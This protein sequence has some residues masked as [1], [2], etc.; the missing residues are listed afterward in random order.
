MHT[1]LSS[2]A[3]KTKG[4]QAYPHRIPAYGRVLE[5]VKYPTG[6]ENTELTH[7]PSPDSFL[8][9]SPRS[10]CLTLASFPYYNIYEAKPFR[11]QESHG[12]TV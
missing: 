6:T 2:L 7:L 5:T 1:I 10:K 12:E 8:W 3:L 11:V 9:I 4:R